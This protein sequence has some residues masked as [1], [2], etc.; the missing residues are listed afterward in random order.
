MNNETILK[1]DGSPFASMA[2]A[3]AKQTILEKDGVRTKP[4]EVEE[5]FA[6]EVIQKKRPKRVPLG[7][8]N[9]LT[10]EVPEGYRGRVVNDRGDRIKRFEAA[11]WRVYKGDT[12]LGDNRVGDARSLGSAVSKPVG[13]DRDGVINGVLMI[14]PED[15]FKE[16]YMEKQKEIDRWEK[17][18]KLQSKIQGQYGKIRIGTI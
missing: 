14:K 18:M 12:Q 16:D 6:L 5:G 13:T 15:E 4:V 9:V 1:E 17:Q 3:K 8:R 7:K 2:A 10:A 11:G